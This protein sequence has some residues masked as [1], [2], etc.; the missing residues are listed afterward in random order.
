MHSF[1]EIYIVMEI[2]DSDLGKLCKQDVTLT[3]LHIN[4]LL[5]NLLAGVNYI[6]S[7]GIYHRDLK[8]AN[9][10]VNQDCTVKIGD[11]GLAR[12]LG[13][14]FEVEHQ[15][16]TPRNQH[17]ENTTGKLPHVPHTERL[18]K[19]LTGHVVTRWYR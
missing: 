12:A 9:C 14:E 8:P 16:D 1:D 5:Y 15:T 7:A 10:F 11:F 4:T 6:H 13:G 19:K 18:K 3:P 2:A 17:A